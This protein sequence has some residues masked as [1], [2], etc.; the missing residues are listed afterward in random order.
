MRR[1]ALY[2]VPVLVV[3]VFVVECIRLGSN[4][5][6]LFKRLCELVEYYLIYKRSVEFLLTRAIQST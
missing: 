4:T 3:V 2:R 6:I 5:R 1:Y